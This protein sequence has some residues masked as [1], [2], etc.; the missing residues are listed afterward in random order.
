MVLWNIFKYKSPRYL[1]EKSTMSPHA[2]VS[3]LAESCDLAG[4][5]S[6]F[7][8][9]VWSVCWEVTRPSPAS[10]SQHQPSPTLIPVTGAKDGGGT[11]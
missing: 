3:T 11:I 1:E 2:R 6:R 8:M 4:E 7:C 10:T 5:R 9:L